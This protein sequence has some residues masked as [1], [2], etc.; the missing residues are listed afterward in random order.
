MDERKEM[1]LTSLWLELDVYNWL[2]EM[3]ERNH[4]SKAHVVRMALRDFIKK[5]CPKKD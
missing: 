2:D 3:A 4:V 5:T 1:K